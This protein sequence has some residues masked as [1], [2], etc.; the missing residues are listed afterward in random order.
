[1]PIIVVRFCF[2]AYFLFESSNG[3]LFTIFESD[4]GYK[5]LRKCAALSSSSSSKLQILSKSIT[6]LFCASQSLSSWRCWLTQVGECC[7]TLFWLQD[8]TEQLALVLHTKWNSILLGYAFFLQV[9]TIQYGFQVTF[10]FFSL[11]SLNPLKLLTLKWT[12]KSLA[13]C[14]RKLSQFKMDFFDD[15]FFKAS[16]LVICCI[17]K[18]KNKAFFICHWFYYSTGDKC[19][20]TQF[21]LSLAFW[22]SSSQAKVLM[23]QSTRW[24]YAW[25]CKMTPYVT[26]LHS[27]PL[28]LAFPLYQVINKGYKGYK[29]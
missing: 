19:D 21:E 23:M 7:C 13:K 1:M 4:M 20:G 16:K 11:N 18:T 15:F 5:I 28:F 2:Q 14:V 12:F 17:G 9:L 25:I 29:L 26:R 3:S 24:K 22:S 27:P 6:Y 10:Q 8:K